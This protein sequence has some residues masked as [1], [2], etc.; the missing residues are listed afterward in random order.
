MDIDKIPINVLYAARM[1][2]GAESQNDTS[3]DERI[4]KMT[5]CQLMRSWSGWHSGSTLY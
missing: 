4:E 2:L 3:D 1:R 5:P